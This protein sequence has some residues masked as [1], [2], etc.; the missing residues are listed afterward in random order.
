MV[1][2]KRTR[3]AQAE[4]IHGR[5]C[6]C[7]IHTKLDYDT[8][9]LGLQAISLPI[10]RAIVPG[11]DARVHKHGGRILESNGQVQ[12]GPTSIK[13]KRGSLPETVFISRLSLEQILREYVQSISTIEVIQGLVTGVVA[14]AK[15]QKI[16][17]VIVQAKGTSAGAI[18]LSAA[19]FAD[20]SGP[21]TIGL[22]L[23]EKA[24]CAGW[25]PYP[26]TS[27]GEWQRIAQ[28]RR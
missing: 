6:A 16:E 12:L 9:I 23:L 7:P 19:M 11:F 20:C 17:Q 18:E 24:Q 28:G 26:K 22:R 25:G 13:F 27:Y 4:Q 1:E 8:L 5:S 3:V 21:A 2:L 14:D 10:L 15:K